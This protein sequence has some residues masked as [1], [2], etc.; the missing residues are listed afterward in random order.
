ML[1]GE[2]KYKT[3]LIKKEENV[4]LDYEKALLLEDAENVEDPEFIKRVNFILGIGRPSADASTNINSNVSSNPPAPEAPANEW[5]SEGKKE[6]MANPS[7]MV[8]A[9]LAVAPAASVTVTNLQTATYPEFKHV[10]ITSTRKPAKLAPQE[11]VR[12]K[13]AGLEFT[14]RLISDDGQYCNVAF[15]DGR[16]STFL[17]S[18]LTR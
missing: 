13:Y 7:A 14:G 15:P 18:Q 5:V 10:Q 8:Q 1:S 12:V 4:I 3:G 11:E 6:L 16:Q 2:V 17:K 9:K